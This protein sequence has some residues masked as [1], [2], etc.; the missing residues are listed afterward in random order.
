MGSLKDMCKHMHELHI[1]NPSAVMICK[2]TPSFY[3]YIISCCFVG[4]VVLSTVT[5]SLVG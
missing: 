1:K 5:A 2:Y 3:Y 4:N